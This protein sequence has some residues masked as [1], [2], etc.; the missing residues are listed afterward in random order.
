MYDQDPKTCEESVTTDWQAFASPGLLSVVGDCASCGVDLDVSSLD[1]L[2]EQLLVS[3][4]DCFLELCWAT[5]VHD[6]DGTAPPVLRRNTRTRARS[7]KSDYYEPPAASPAL[8]PVARAYPGSF[9]RTRPS[10]A[11]MTL[12][13]ET[14]RTLR[15]H[16]SSAR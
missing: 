11:K 3:P 10:A 13:L 2:D 1:A 15:A 4:V 6:D 16:S 8:P 12:P 14:V 7:F 9:E 5:A